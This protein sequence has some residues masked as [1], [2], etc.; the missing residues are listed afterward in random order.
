MRRVLVIAAM[1]ASLAAPVPAHANG[2]P[3]S[4]VLLMQDAF[5]PYSPEVPQPVQKGLNDTLEAMRKKGFPLKVAIIASKNDLGAIPQFYGAPQPY[6][7]HLESE[8]AFDEPKPLLI[9]MPTGFGVAEA[10]P[11][12]QEALEDVDAPDAD[13]GDSLGRAAIAGARA[14]AE[15]QGKPVPQPKLPPPE[16]SGGGTSPVVFLVPVLLLALGG[17]LAA[18]RARQLDKKEEAAAP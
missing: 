6:A 15:A 18:V 1:L 12:A 10:G 7:D 5:F 16:D 4:D 17:G 9:V 2:D 14:L 11:R 3:A 13:S 8:I